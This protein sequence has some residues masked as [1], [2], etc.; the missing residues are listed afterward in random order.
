[1]PRWV[2]ARSAA[3]AV[4]LLAACGPEAPQD[5]TSAT[6]STTTSLPQDPTS[7]APTGDPTTGPSDP[8]TT[9]S[10]TS[11]T[12]STSTTDDPTVTTSSTTGLPPGVCPPACEQPAVHVGDVKLNGVAAGEEFACVRHIDGALSLRGDLGPAELAA[13]T[14]L[15]RVSSLSITD[16][17]VLTTLDALPCLHT[18]DQFVKLQDTPALTDVSRLGQLDTL[19]VLSLTATGVTTLPTFGPAHVGLNFIELSHNP[20]LVDL[21]PI[22]DWRAHP[23]QGLTILIHDNDNLTS[24]EGL[25]GIIANPPD[26]FVTLELWRLPQLASLKGLEPLKFGTLQLSSLPLVPD[27]LPLSGLI[28]A[29]QLRLSD[30]PLV[31]DLQGL[32]N[33]TAVEGLLIGPCLNGGP[34]HPG[35]PGLKDLSGLDKLVSASTLGL[36]NTGMTALTG[37]PALHAVITLDIVANDGLTQADVDQLLSQLD[38]PPIHHCFGDWGECMC[39]VILP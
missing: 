19:P 24:I 1:M 23:N 3:L 30:M 17:T 16:N 20:A 7:G 36:A 18:V 2:P 29:D 34:D 31:Q 22:A 32:N 4:L 39:V 11:T 9:T 10:T 13:L 8:T 35:M 6:S 33:L 5:S 26:H 28:E 38:A 25:A 12:T 27:L 21:D 14:R 37:A 15:E